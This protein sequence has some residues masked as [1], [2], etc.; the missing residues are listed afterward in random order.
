MYRSFFS[1]HHLPFINTPDEAFFFADAQYAGMLQAIQYAVERGDALI[2]VTGEVGTGK[3]TLLRL[4]AERLRKKGFHLVFISSPRLSAEEMLAYIA[5][6]LNID[7]STG[8][9][10]FH[11]YDKLSR[12]L[13]ATY[14]Q[15]E[16]IVILIDEAHAIPLDTLEEIRLLGNIETSKEKLVQILL[17][18]QPELNELLDRPEARQLKSRI[19]HSF[20]LKPLSESALHEYLNYRMRKA[21]Y[22]GPPVFDSAVAARI[23]QLTQGIPRLVNNVADKLLVSAYLHQ[24]RKVEL[25]DFRHLGRN[26]DDQEKHGSFRNRSV[27]MW[28]S[29][30]ALLIGMTV[31]FV[32]LFRPERLLSFMGMDTKTLPS[33]VSSVTAPADPDGK[34]DAQPAGKGRGISTSALEKRVSHAHLKAQEEVQAEAHVSPRAQQE[35]K[36]TP[37]IPDRVLMQVEEKAIPGR[38]FIDMGQVLSCRQMKLRLKERDLPIMILRYVSGRNY[39]CEKLIGPFESL[40]QAKRV[41]LSGVAKRGMILEKISIVKRIRQ[42]S[43]EIVYEY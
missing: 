24:R 1:L 34:T 17:F 9:T 29:L 20:E 37:E 8:D 16:R 30:V 13:L 26:P 23:H 40:I 22:L 32:L 2:K 31:I 43:A 33:S 7:V 6:E 10:K 12:Y 5:R 42:R 27:L 28:S 3:T 35:E 36:K 15:G 14:S 41:L 38:Y 21:G 19:T 18:G 39:L 25:E 11:L 4:L